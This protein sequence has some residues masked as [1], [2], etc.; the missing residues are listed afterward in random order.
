MITHDSTSPRISLD[1]VDRALLEL[2]RRSARTP[3]SEL[4]RAV[5]LSPAPVSRRIE[6]LER[7]GVIRGYVT[8]IDDQVAG[9]LDA[10][11]E[12][13]LT[14]DTE[15]GVLEEDLRTMDEVQNFFTVAGDPDVLVRLRVRDV[16][17]LQ[18]VVNTIRRTG[19]ATGTKTLIVMYDWT[20]GEDV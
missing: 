5:N 18:R 3:V 20:R 2:L 9:D 6:R 13:R 1:A 16:D 10:F 8:V 15:T 14:G 4:A 17:H 12:I 11:V 7:H 19:K